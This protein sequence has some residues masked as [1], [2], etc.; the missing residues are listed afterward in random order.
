MANADDLEQDEQMVF[1]PSEW[2]GQGKEYKDVPLY[3][4]RALANLKVAPESQQAIFP[5]PDIPVLEF[6]ERKFA[7]HER[8]LEAI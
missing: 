3:M 7:Q 1:L 6:V 2:I 4:C 8:G 5:S